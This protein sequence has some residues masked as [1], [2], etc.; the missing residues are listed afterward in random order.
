MKEATR[1]HRHSLHKPAGLGS[2]KELEKEGR[3]EKEEEE[4]E[5]VGHEGGTVPTVYTVTR[6]KTWRNGTLA[7]C[8]SV[9]RLKDS[10]HAL[11]SPR[12]FSFFSTKIHLPR[13]ALA[14]LSLFSTPLSFSLF[15]PFSFF[16]DPIYPPIHLSGEN[17]FHQ[18][19]KNSPDDLTNREGVLYSLAAIVYN[20]GLIKYLSR[21]VIE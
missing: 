8:K 6:T 2:R 19:R 10:P 7:L 15:L 17:S 3:E 5:E 11:P 16:L 21:T 14:I 20:I 18:L 9:K 1:F 12:S 4:E 13:L